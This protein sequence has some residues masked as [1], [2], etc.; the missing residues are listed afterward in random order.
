MVGKSERIEVLD[1]WRAPAAIMVAVAHLTSNYGIG[2][3]GVQIFFAISGFVICRGLIHESSKFGRVSLSAFYIRRAF[4]ILPPLMFYVAVIMLLTDVGLLP[5]Q[6]KMVL[7]ALTFT[8][9]LPGENCGGWLGQHTWTLSAEEQFYIVIPAL[10]IVLGNLRRSVFSAT[11]ISLPFVVIALFFMKF[12]D[13]ALF[14]SS[15]VTICFGIACA[16]NEEVIRKI[17]ASAPRLIVIVSAAALLI[18]TQYP[19]SKTATTLQLLFLGPLIVFLL[20]RTMTTSSPFSRFLESSPMRQIGFASYS[21]YLW[22]E[23]AT[24]PASE[25]HSK[26]LSVTM[27]AVVLAFALI[28]FHF[29]ERHLIE[30]GRSIVARRR[31]APQAL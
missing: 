14:L 10:F 16:L 8:C 3:L 17:S 23:P 29:V 1:G 21:L 20:T 27:F 15:F 12:H 18:L 19:T 22:Q 24:M 6:A 28:S 25:G 13:A 5:D 31:T 30:A 26:W 9:D 11:A 7:R 2:I 4:R